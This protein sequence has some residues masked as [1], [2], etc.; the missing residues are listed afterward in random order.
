MQT[1]NGLLFAQLL[2]MFTISLTNNSYPVCL[3]QPF[4]APLGPE[5]VKDC[6]LGLH[7]VCACQN[8]M[9]FVFAQTIIHGA[10]LVQDFEKAGDYFVMNV[11]DHTRYLFLCCLKS[12]TV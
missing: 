10:P 12:F 3:V 4:D 6:E 11:V 7:H 8:V 5:H 1:T 2:L 9:E